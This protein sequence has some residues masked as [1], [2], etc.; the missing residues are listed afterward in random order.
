MPVKLDIPDE[1]L[2]KFQPFLRVYA[3]GETILREGQ[4]PDQRV[5]LLRQGE[6]EVI[7]KSGHSRNR[8]APSPPSTFLAK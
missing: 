5:F 7:K 4:V 3:K 8:W 1:E 2:Q 6:V